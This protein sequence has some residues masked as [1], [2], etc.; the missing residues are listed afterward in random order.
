[1]PYSL[2][3]A[4][5]NPCPQCRTAA[6][7]GGLRPPVN[8]STPAGHGGLHASAHRLLLALPWDRC[9]ASRSHLGCT[10][11]GMYATDPRR[12]PVL[13]SPN[14]LNVRNGSIAGPTPTRTRRAGRSTSSATPPSSTWPPTDAPPPS[15][16]PNPGI[17]TWAASAGTSSSA[18]RPPPRSPPAQTPQHDAGL[19]DQARITPHHRRS[20]VGSLDF[21]RL[22]LGP[23][24]RTAIV[25]YHPATWRPGTRSGAEGRDPRGRGRHQ[26]PDAARPGPD[27][28]PSGPS[29]ATPALAP[30][31]PPPMSPPATPPHAVG[32]G[33]PRRGNDGGRYLAVMLIVGFPLDD[34]SGPSSRKLVMR[35]VKLRRVASRLVRSAVQ[36]IAAVAGEQAAADRREGRRGQPPSLG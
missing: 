28:P 14:R 25:I 24:S 27:T 26:H 18:S 17:C 33:K 12:L 32:Q 11:T 31:P 21:P 23:R 15:S 7:L 20:A 34:P 30:R 10:G 3:S 8:P 2:R 13:A 1:M 22:L 9:P 19:A 16:R 29:S 5:R 36:R 35:H 4:G 6:N